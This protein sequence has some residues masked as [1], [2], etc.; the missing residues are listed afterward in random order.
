M[1]PARFGLAIGNSGAVGHAVG[2]NRT[3]ARTPFRVSPGVASKAR[4]VD[5]QADQVVAP[6]STGAGCRFRTTVAAPA[7][8]I[9]MSL[10]DPEKS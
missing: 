10:P 6:G 3:I 9:A 4:Q 8:P 5:E 1:I 7:T 2:H